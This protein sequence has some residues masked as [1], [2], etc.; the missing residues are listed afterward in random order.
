M[1]DKVKQLVEFWIKKN[2][3]GGKPTPAE[4]NL[5]AAN[6]QIGVIKE[7]VK[8]IGFETYTVIADEISNLKTEQS[9]S[10]A[11]GKFNQPSDFMF[12]MGLSSTYTDGVIRRADID[13]LRENEFNYKANSLIVNPVSSYPIARRLDG[14]YE[15]L[16]SSISTIRCVY[17]RQ[18]ADPIWAYTE[19][20]GRPI[21]NASGST[22][23]ELPLSMIERLAYGILSQMGINVRE[24]QVISNAESQKNE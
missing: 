12:L 23:F 13:L 14:K 24:N 16:P 9:L 15:I 6:E 3:N 5:L 17:I 4:F 18:P 20:N 2:R 1:I 8:L 7:S 21:Y 10:I 22:D 19:P 11:A